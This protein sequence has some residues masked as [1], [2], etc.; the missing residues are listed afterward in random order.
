LKYLN[1]IKYGG[2]L[3]IKGKLVIIYILLLEVGVKSESYLTILLFY[4]IGSAV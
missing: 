3:A 4:L 2:S 1:F